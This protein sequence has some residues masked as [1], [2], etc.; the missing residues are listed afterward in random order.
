LEEEW[1]K[2]EG[3]YGAEGEAVERTVERVRRGLS[4]RIG[5]LE[6]GERK[7][8]VAVTHGV[9][10]KFLSGDEGIELLK[11][12]WKSYTGEEYGEGRAVELVVCYP[13]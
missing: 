4:E 12:G 6:G 10:M 11:A 9:F 3:I 5:G 8:V 13:S 1:N 7:D 2:K